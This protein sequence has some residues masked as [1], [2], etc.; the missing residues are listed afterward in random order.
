MAVDAAGNIYVAGIVSSKTNTYQD[1]VIIKYS[2]SG[3]LAWVRTYDASFHDNDGYYAVGVDGSGNVIATGF[4]YQ[5][6]LNLADIVTVKYNSAGVRQ[7]L[8]TYDDPEGLDD[9]AQALAIDKQGNALVTGSRGESCAAEGGY[10][11]SYVTV[12]YSPTGVQQWIAVYNPKPTSDDMASAVKVDPA[13]NVYVT[14]QSA[15]QSAFYDF[16]TVKYT[17]AGKQ[18]WAKRY[19]GVGKGNDMA[20][21]L[22]VDSKGNVIVVGSSYVSLQSDSDFTVIK[23][24]SSGE[25]LW[26]RRYNGPGSGIDM[27]FFVEVDTLRYIYAT[28]FSVGTYTTAEDFVTIKYAP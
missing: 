9:W 4:S 28:G 19:D 16:A 1:A 24:S 5:S 3:P 26:V 2:A 25:Q 22:A 10:C 12:K 14:G 21:G 17:S 8:K 27:A 7:W 11:F 23:Y 13:G 6:G 18:V 15:W 20:H